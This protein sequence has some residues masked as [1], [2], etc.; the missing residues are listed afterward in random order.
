MDMAATEHCST[1]ISTPMD[2]TA[3]EQY[4]TWVLPPMDVTATEQ[5]S[6]WVSPSVS[7]QLPE[8]TQSRMSSYIV[9]EL[10]YTYAS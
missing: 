10:L 9:I 3:T 1:C 2:V 8:W 4:S 5:Y 6:T 7:G